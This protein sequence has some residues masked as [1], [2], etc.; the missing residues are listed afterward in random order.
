MRKP[1]LFLFCMISFISNAQ[2]VIIS[3]NF[4]SYTAGA[5]LAANSPLW[6]TW[7]GGVPAEDADVDTAQSFSAPN[8][9]Y[10]IGNNGPTD[11]VLPFPANYAAG[12]YELSMKMFIVTGKGAYFNLQSSMTPG[13]DW[14]F[15]A[16]FDNTGAGSINAGGTGSATF[17]YV[18]NAWTDIKVNVDL[19]NDTARFYVDNSI[20]HTW[21]WSFGSGGTV[22]WG[23]L[24]IYAAATTPP[25]DAEFYVD[26]VVLTDLTVTGIEETSPFS[27]I[28]VY[29][30]PSQGNFEL[31]YFSKTVS[32]ATLQ[33]FSITGE[34]IMET[35]QRIVAGRNTI[36]VNAPQLSD[37]MYLLRL[38]SGDDM[39]YKKIII[40]N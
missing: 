14:M 11:L 12:V 7:S 16:Y 13:V 22:M 34:K 39:I 38:Q 36:S 25:G 10:I 31:D 24:N 2:T 35:P 1:V 9:V 19:T 33:L 5:P 40:E 8:S 27:S 17:N 20:I 6:T 37:G 29:P 21:Q 3:D 23:G 4:D 30:N 15:E 28:R 26:D 18:P 32:N